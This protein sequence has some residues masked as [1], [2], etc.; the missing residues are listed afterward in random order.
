METYFLVT[1]LRMPL[2]IVT[3]SIVHLHSHITIDQCYLSKHF[4]FRINSAVQFR[5]TNA[6]LSTRENVLQVRAYSKVKYNIIKY[7]TVKYI[8]LMSVKHSAIITCV[9]K[10][11]FEKYFTI[12]KLMIYQLLE[13]CFQYIKNAYFKFLSC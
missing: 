4:N 9:M 3:F 11:I 13:L 6:V 2:Q 5:T 8:A 12:C 10:Y 7:S 1:C